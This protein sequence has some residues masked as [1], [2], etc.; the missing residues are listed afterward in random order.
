MR[1]PRSARAAAPLAIAIALSVMTAPPARAQLFKLQPPSHPDTTDTTK[2]AAAVAPDS[3]RAAVSAFLDLTQHG[4]YGQAAQ[5]L[6]LPDSMRARGAEL[7]RE[8]R[9]VL[10]HYVWIDLDEV[11]GA[12][13]GDTTDGF[14][15]GIDQLAT[16]PGTQGGHEPV[17]LIR[18]SD[19]QPPRWVFSLA[20]V[21]RT[22]RWYDALPDRWTLEHL[23]KALLAAGPFGILRWQ[24]IALAVLIALAWVAGAVL[25]RIARVVFGRLAARTS[26]HWDDELF[27]RLGGPFTLAA[28]LI[29]LAALLPILSLNA[30]ARGATAKLVSA[31]LL[32]TLFWALWRMVDVARLVM[33]ETGWVAQGS[34]GRGLVVLGSR[35]AKVAIAAL[36]VVAVLA[37]LGYPVAALIGGL[38][39]G[40]LALA[41][42]A[43]K[44]VENL[45]GAF[46][47]AADR[48]FREGDYVSVD[49]TTGNI[50]AI[51]LRSTRI[52]TLDRTIVVLPNAK[53]AESRIES[54]AA[55]D[56]LRLACVIGL[57]YDT[58]V[59]QMRTVLAGF[60]R[61]LRE[62]P[63]IWPDGITVRFV[64][65]SASS[66]D[67]QIMAWFRTTDWDEFQLI[68]QTVLLAFMEVVDAAQTS[69]A[70]PTQ[71]MHVAS[72]PPALLGGKS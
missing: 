61:V 57:V 34:G 28:T 37:A 29:V 54:F 23:P 16:I 42:A 47:L 1:V 49:G 10:D 43:Q 66:L 64:A 5:Y 50:E 63:K 25:S 9:V 24:W 6:D 7:A 19:A 36:G 11:S 72:V 39:L 45:F 32:L 15:H 31:G 48:V 58:T 65:L 59:E 18:L 17:R 35:V 26:T 40:G 70:F 51:G 67:I 41:L 52:R 56:R 62:Q 21:E 12:P 38:G 2:H 46:S 30:G 13:A 3:P 33:S 71:T 4:Q 44:T 68:R 14:P 22:P 55:R 60:E 27:R 69:F 8:L 53:V 20:T